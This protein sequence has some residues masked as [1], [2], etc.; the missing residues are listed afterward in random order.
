MF[1]YGNFLLVP[2]REKVWDVYPRGLMFDTKNLICCIQE[3]PY[4][5]PVTGD[6]GSSKRM[7]TVTAKD[8]PGVGNLEQVVKGDDLENYLDSVYEGR[9]AL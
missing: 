3:M 7:Y 5:N 2:V 4:K 8:Y 9:K 6:F 1:Y